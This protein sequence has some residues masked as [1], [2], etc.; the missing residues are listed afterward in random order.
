LDWEVT[1]TLVLLSQ[2]RFWS[3]Q[4]ATSAHE[5]FSLA[6]PEAPVVVPFTLPVPPPPVPLLLVP[7]PLVPQA[8]ARATTASK[9]PRRPNVIKLF[10]CSLRF[11]GSGLPRAL[12]GLSASIQELGQDIGGLVGV[13]VSCRHLP[14][15]ELCAAVPFNLSIS[16]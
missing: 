1:H 6:H 11:A 5:A 4:Q 8:T 15:Q 7:P 16:I 3:G 13:F 10:M 2:V 9:A 14:L 12:F